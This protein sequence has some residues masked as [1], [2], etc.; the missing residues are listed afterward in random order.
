MFGEIYRFELRYQLRQPLFWIASLVFFLVSFLA[1]TT[2]AVVIGGS[3]G[4]VH[5]NAPYVIMQLIAVMSILGVFVV[6]AFVAGTVIRD[7]EHRTRELFFS[8]PMKKRDYLLGRFCGALTVALSIYLPVALGIF[9]GARMPWIETERVGPFAGGAYLFAL[10]VF[11]LPNTVLS[12]AAFFAIATRTRSLLATYSGVVGFFVAYLIAG[13]LLADVENEKVASLVDPFGGAAFQIDTR[14]WTV[15]E[16]NSQILDFSGPLLT[17]RL[18]WLAV[19]L[20]LFVWTYWRFS[21]DVQDRKVWRFRW[22]PGRDFEE[23]ARGARAATQGSAPEAQGLPAAGLHVQTVERPRVQ[24]RFG[25]AMAWQQLFHQT[26]FEMRAVVRSLA[27]PILLAWGV[28]NMVGNSGVIDQ[29]FGTPV[30]PVTHLMIA[31]F[32]GA[33]LFLFLVITVYTAEVV[34]RERSLDLDEMH[35]ALPTPTWAIWGSKLTAMAFIV[36]AL[37][38]VGILTGMGIQVWRGYFHFEILLYLQ[39]ML[40]VVGIPFVLASVL[41][42]FFQAVGNNKYLGILLM[43]LFF[44]LRYALPAWD[45]DHRLYQYAGFVP[46][47]YS[48]M[49]GYGHFVQPIF[50]YYLYWSFLAV[51]LGVAIH[52]FWIRGKAE[53]WRHRFRIARQRFSRPVVATL[54]AA[55]VA[56]LATGGWIFYNTNIVNEYVP[57]DLQEAR[58]AQWEKDYKQYESLPQPRITAVYADVDIYPDERAVN[59]RGRYTLRNKNEVPVGSLHLVLDPVVERRDFTIPGAKLSHEDPT[60]G[61]S[62]WDFDRP[63][64]PGEEIEISFDLGVDHQGF[65]NNNADRRLVENGTFFNSFDFFPSIGYQRGREL[66]DPNDRRKHGLEPLQRMPKIDDEAARG[67]NYLTR[68]S[69]WIDFETVVSTRPDQ[70]ALA[71]GYLQREWEENGR[72]YFH[73]KMDA[74]ILGFWAYL[75]ADWEV[76]RDR[77]NDVAIEVYYHPDHPYNVQRMIEATKASLDYFTREFGPYQHRQVRIVE[78]P[79]YARFAQSFPNTIP[80]SESIGFIARL[81]EDDEEPIDYVFYVTAHEVAHQWWAHQVIGANVQGATVLSET[82]SQYSALMVM[83]KEYGADQ[84]RRFL[85]YELDNYLRSRGGELLEE[86]P[87]MLVENQGYIHY[88]KGSVVMYAL[89]DYV[90]EESLN[91]AIRRYAEAVRFQ[92]PPYTTTREFLSYISEAVPSRYDGLLDDLFRE[93]TLYENRAEKAT[94]R[95]QADGTYLV[96]LEIDA[97]KLRADGQGEETKVP[98]DTWVDVAVFGEKK[99]GSPPEGE[100]LAM[101]K[102][103]VTGSGIVELVVDQEPRRAGIDPYNKLIDRNPENNVVKVSKASETDEETEKEREVIIGALGGG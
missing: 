31:I 28:L 79:R 91:R 88:R 39:G 36:L 19:A 27:F 48:D 72:R 9:L 61:Y 52:L 95:Q 100:V 58:Q 10:L 18:L 80:F 92:E 26:R 38:V 13:N 73:Y 65:V 47:A 85:K 99:E 81:D 4:H 78:F 11:A 59:I 97:Q 102:R 33:S 21:F 25:G 62:I 42:I 1:T 89:K 103:R 12:S 101:E 71:P 2:D 50:W 55:L 87:L 23:A 43:I 34:W 68:Q 14:Y 93:I 82:M 54:A 86:L 49:N 45:Y 46:S 94:W 63:L 5:R 98:M 16:R 15:A 17:N 66:N 30:Y 37:M 40:L 75:S 51:I 44:I 32:Q 70:I 77:W 29:L 60:L 24:P 74:P 83:E 22:R 84:M 67:G 7:Q 41:G 64:Q 76:A 57:G 20:V 53:G 8:T 69:D 96:R 56:S 35:D 90:G 3:I 6:T